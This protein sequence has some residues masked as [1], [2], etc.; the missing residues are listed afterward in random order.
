MATALW[1]GGE[2]FLT[3][4]PETA[5][6]MTVAMVSCLAL[7]RDWGIVSLPLPQVERQVPS[8][9]FEQRPVR[10]ALQFGLELGLG[11]RTYVSASLPYVLAA[12][13]LLLVDSVAVAVLGGIGFGLGRFLMAGA[14]YAS[15]E[16]ERWDDLLEEREVVL[17]RVTCLAGTALTLGAV[18]LV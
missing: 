1:A 4:L 3:W 12:V 7:A 9:V 14:R 18:I 15:V 8:T 10:A 5:S 11:V 17:V 2:L 13:I 6:L 16:G